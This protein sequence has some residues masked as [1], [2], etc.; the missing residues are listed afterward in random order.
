MTLLGLSPSASPEDIA[1]AIDEAHAYA[2]R[3]NIA[4]LEETLGR[5]PRK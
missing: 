2:V 5:R 1:Q 4:D 3:A